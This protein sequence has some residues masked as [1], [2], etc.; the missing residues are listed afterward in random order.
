MGAGSASGNG[1]GGGAVV[2][3]DVEKASAKAAHVF[4]SHCLVLQEPRR[5]VMAGELPVPRQQPYRSTFIVRAS[6]GNSS[7]PAQSSRKNVVTY[8]RYD[9]MSGLWTLLCRQNFLSRTSQA[10][11]T[12]EARLHLPLWSDKRIHYTWYGDC[13]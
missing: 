7:C 12:G 8:S 11:V 10:G 6:D 5:L 9:R 1:I 13:M 4:E 2:P 3:L